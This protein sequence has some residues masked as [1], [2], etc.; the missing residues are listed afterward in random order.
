MENSYCKK[1]D[2]VDERSKTAPQF[3]PRSTPDTQ[4]QVQEPI[5]SLET[6]TAKKP[7]EK[8]P[9]TSR[10]EETQTRDKKTGAT[11]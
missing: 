10:K 7:E 5:V 1:K 2:I 6:T 9:R 8:R 4:K 3:A 11:M